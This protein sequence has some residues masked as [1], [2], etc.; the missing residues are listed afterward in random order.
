[1]HPVQRMVLSTDDAR[2]AKAAELLDIDFKTL[3]AALTTNFDSPLYLYCFELGRVKQIKHCFGIGAFNECFKHDIVLS[4]G[5]TRDIE[6]V[7]TEH[8]RSMYTCP[9]PILKHLVV[10]DAD[11]EAD[12][13][14]ALDD[15][16]NSPFCT[17]TLDMSIS[18][19]IMATIPEQYISFATLFY[20]SAS[21]YSGQLEYIESLLKV[22]MKM[23][24]AWTV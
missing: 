12:A 3:R 22:K 5:F 10:I 11:A 17:R 14:M 15:F 23:K 16:Y 19:S 6:A 20:T 13:H 4:T 8:T 9:S 21:R 2:I 1:M 7:K 24:R 18:G